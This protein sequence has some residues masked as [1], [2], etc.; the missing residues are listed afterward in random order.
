MRNQS[1][2]PV[3]WTNY[4]HTPSPERGSPSHLTGCETGPKLDSTPGKRSETPA[5]GSAPVHFGSASNKSHTVN[6]YWPEND[7]TPFFHETDFG[8]EPLHFGTHLGATTNLDIFD[9]DFEVAKAARAGRRAIPTLSPLEIY[10]ETIGIVPDAPEGA[11]DTLFLCTLALKRVLLARK[12]V[13]YI[14]KHG[15][16]RGPGGL[17]LSISLPPELE[18]PMLHA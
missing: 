8:G 14:R 6:C 11:V 13:E 16:V 17:L 9:L 12:M 18:V 3:F 15:H 5:S 10:A 7:P 2:E 1:E 4:V